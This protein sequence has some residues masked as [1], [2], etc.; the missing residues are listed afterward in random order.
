MCRDVINFEE[1][2]KVRKKTLVSSYT[3]EQKMIKK[4]IEIET[5]DI[6]C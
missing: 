4:I 5:I 3:A 2:K 1:E 6:M